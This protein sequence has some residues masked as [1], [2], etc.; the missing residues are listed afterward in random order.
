MGLERAAFELGMEKIGELDSRVKDS[1]GRTVL[2]LRN[3]H[4]LEI[5]FNPRFRRE[6]PPDTKDLVEKLRRFMI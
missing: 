3:L 2:G 1:W 6:R 5:W 4:R